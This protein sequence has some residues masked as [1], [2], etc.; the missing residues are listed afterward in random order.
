MC[1]VI[2]ALLD[3]WTQVMSLALSPRSRISPI[4]TT[5]GKGVSIGTCVEGFRLASHFLVFSR[6]S[7][8]TVPTMACYKSD[9]RDKCKQLN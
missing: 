4:W 1:F 2:L 9:F 8:L 3:N 6:P 7:V 5:I